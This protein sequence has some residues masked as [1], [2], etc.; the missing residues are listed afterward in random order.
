[1]AEDT[2]PGQSDASAASHVARSRGRLKIFLGMA[3]GVGKTYTMLSEAHRR[4]SRGEDVVIGYLE[5]HNRPET[6]ALSAGLETVPP[7]RIVHRGIEFSEMDTEAILRRRPLWALVDELAHTNVPGTEHVKRWQSVE[8]LLRAGINVITTVNIQHLESL[9]DTVEAI[10]G[11]RVRETFPDRLIREADEVVV[12][13]L[14]P[15]ALINRLRRGVVYDMEK[16]DRALVS[17]FTPERLAA[18]RELALR[19][20]A[21]EVD[22]QMLAALGDASEVAWAGREVVVVCVTARP[23]SLR[24]VR[25]GFRLAERLHAELRVLHVTATGHQRTEDEQRVIDY[26]AET[27]TNLGAHIDD[28]R[29]DDVASEIVDYALDHRATFLV[30]GQSVRT[31]LEEI[32]RGSIVTRVMRETEGMD[33]VIVSDREEGKGPARRR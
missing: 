7:K 12:V 33:V 28:V 10:T 31:R 25:R 9:N 13:D 6:A 29:G 26:V 2:A 8:D 30:L 11:V 5:P 16:V 1:M 15:Q 19:Q 32:V 27:A 17:F 22:D 23:E 18:L 20:T 24:L 14:T 3:A 21:D 4:A